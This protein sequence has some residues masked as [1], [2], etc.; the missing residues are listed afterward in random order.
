MLSAALVRL[1]RR[2]RENF[3]HPTSRILRVY[4]WAVWHDR[5]VSWACVRENWAGAKPPAA[6]PD[7]S[8]L[9]RR[10]RDERTG[11]MLDELL[12]ELDDAKAQALVRRLDGKPLTV[13][14]HSQDKLAGFGRGAGGN[15]RGYKLHT[16]YGNSNRPTLTVLPLDVDERV[17]AAELIDRLPTSGYL[18]ADAFYDSGPLYDQAAAAGHVL[19]TPPRRVNRGQGHR[20]QS[21]S[22]LAAERRLTAPGDFARDLL[23]TRKQI[24]SRLAHLC[25]FGGGL[26]C[27]PPWVRGHRVRPYVL[28]KIAVRL[29]RDACRRQSAA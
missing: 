8:T 1:Q 11:G 4:L 19:L 25:N 18:L 3:V 10:L 2:R 9:S 24:E 17:A 22:R 26:T 14:R 6:L 29:A 23:T 28:G 15:D 27:L 5:P 12:D 21:P 13:S 16:I 7:Q 20:P